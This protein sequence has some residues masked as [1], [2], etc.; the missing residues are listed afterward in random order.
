MLNK[1]TLVVLS[2][3]LLFVMALSACNLPG[4]SSADMVDVGNE[5]PGGESEEEEI[6]IEAN[7]VSESESG[8]ESE[9][10]DNMEGDFV[11]CPR[12]GDTL[13][14][15]FDHALTVEMSD[16][17]LTHLLQHKMLILTATGENADGEIEISSGGPIELT[18]EMMGVMSE[19]SVA[20]EGT[21]I[22]TAYGTC[23]DGVVYLT[24][25]EN[26]QPGTGEMV[27]D[28]EVIP[29]QAPGAEYEHSG[30]NGMG[31]MFYLTSDVNGYSTMR[32]FQAGSGYHTW[33]LYSQG[34]ENV[35]LSP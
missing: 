14:L 4:K 12:E 17:N 5:P 18:Y 27:C 2:L 35:P 30:E 25:I 26:W 32:P 10:V 8:G 24:I 31:E 34:I 15:A 3:M 22:A 11:A 20:M 19:C 13:T 21:M 16:V 23:V 1:R 28:D 7:S 29:F 9:T 33:T 6:P